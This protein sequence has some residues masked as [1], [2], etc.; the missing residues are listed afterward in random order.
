MGGALRTMSIT[1]GPPA[2][3]NDEALRT[4]P[5]WGANNAIVFGGN[6]PVGDPIMRVG[7][8]GGVAEPITTL[9]EAE[10]DH[11][12]PHLLPDGN[13]LLFTVVT[14]ENFQI[15]VKSPAT[16]EQQ[17]LGEGSYPRYVSSGHI[18]FVRETQVW[19]VPFDANRLELTGA[20]IP[21]LEGVRGAVSGMRHFA[22]AENGT[23]AYVPVNTGLERTL[24]WVDR[25]GTTEVIDTVPPNAFETPRLSPEGD[26]VLVVADGDAWIYDLASGRET[27]VTSDGAT[28]G[29]AGWT[30]DGEVVYSSERG[31]GGATN[32]WIE[33]ADGSGE[34][35]QLTALDGRVHFD[36]WAPDGLTFSAHHHPTGPSNQ[37]MVPVDGEPEPWLTREFSDGN[38][39]FSPDGR[40]AALVSDQTGQREIVIRPLV[41]PVGQ[42]PV[43][44]GGGEEPAWA[45]NG[46]LFYR[47]PSDYAMMVV[48]VTTDPILDVGPPRELFRG[49][50]SP[51]GSPRARYSVT[52]DGQRFLMSGAHAASEDTGI[53]SVSR[54]QINV[55]LNWDQELLERVPIP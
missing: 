3:V 55:V 2:T 17:V 24:V 25:D 50:V 6:T 39:V 10:T 53:E 41:G 4:G 28:D 40:Y 31:S 54:Q 34:A 44:V 14:N 12:W 20:A 45:A 5:S 13:A 29:Y 7:A 47:R 9:S 46:E 32:V 26:R 42:T 49:T 36:S 43:S 11:R 33:S 21:V 27:R 18:V 16:G 23:L 30:P 48:E 8:T 35:R 22:V 52:L 51:G 38:A 37:L 19:A 15:A 1:G